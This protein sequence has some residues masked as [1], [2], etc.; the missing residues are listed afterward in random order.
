MDDWIIA[1]GLL[2]LGALTEL[3]ASKIIKNK[4]TKTLVVTSIWVVV[5]IIALSL[6]FMRR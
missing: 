2:L 5:L 3:I 1:I 6:W 4:K